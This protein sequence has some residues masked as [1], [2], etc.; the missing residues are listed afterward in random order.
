MV[1]QSVRIINNTACFSGREEGFKPELPALCNSCLVKKAALRMTRKPDEF[2]PRKCK[3]YLS[4]AL[5]RKS[6]TTL[7]SSR[8]KVVEAGNV[9]RTLSVLPDVESL[10]F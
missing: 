7:V 8:I 4:P 6:G 1:L 10:Y 3:P 2:Q 9:G 5:L